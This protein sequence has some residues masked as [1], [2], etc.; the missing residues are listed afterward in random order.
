MKKKIK[1][2]RVFWLTRNCGNGW[3]K[4]HTKSIKKGIDA[5]GQYYYPTTPFFV[6]G[7]C[8]SAFNRRFPNICLEPGSKKKVKITIEVIE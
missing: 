5:N 8:A 4:L 6:Y 1:E 3:Y 2:S 7:F